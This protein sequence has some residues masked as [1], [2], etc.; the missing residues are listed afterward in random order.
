[1]PNLLIV[2]DT[3]T[4]G[5]E[6]IARSVLSGAQIEFQSLLKHAD[7]VSADDLLRSNGYIF[8]CPENLAAISGVMKAFFDR[9][10]YELL[11]R[12]DG[13]PYCQMIC[14]GSD[15]ENAVRQIAKIATGWRLKLVQEPLIVCTHAQTKEEILSPKTI[16]PVSLEKCAAIGQAF[17]AGLALGIY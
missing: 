15:G 11:G 4:G 12:I 5:S 3:M 9:T 1:M 10:Y 13:R 6:A 17:G 2:Y 7:D 14:A 8:V 16:D